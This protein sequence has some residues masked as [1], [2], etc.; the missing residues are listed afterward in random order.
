MIRDHDIG[1]RI[2]HGDVDGAEAVLRRIA[3]IPVAELAAKGARAKALVSTLLGKAE[4]CGRLCDVV[5][6]GVG[7]GVSRA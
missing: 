5:E 1:W 4:L 7:D 2:S 3:D 6:R